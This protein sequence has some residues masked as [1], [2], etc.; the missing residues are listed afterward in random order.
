MRE[1]LG[2]EVLDLGVGVWSVEVRFGVWG[3]RHWDSSS[4]WDPA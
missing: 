1:G 3:L 4:D 2:F